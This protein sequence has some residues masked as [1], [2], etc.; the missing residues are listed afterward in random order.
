M[1]VLPSPANANGSE[2]GITLDLPHFSDIGL[3]GSSLISG[4]FRRAVF[5][6]LESLGGG[7]LE[8][9]DADGV[10]HFGDKDTDLSVVIRVHDSRFYRAVALGGSMGAGESYID[11]AWSCSD[12]TKLIQLFSRNL[13]SSNRLGG[14]ID[15]LISFARRLGHRLNRNTR[16]GSRKNISAHY[17]LSNQF[18]ELFLD[19][20]MTYSSG[21]FTSDDDTMQ[22]ASIEKYDRLCRKLSLCEDDHLLEIGTGWGGFSIH[23]AKHYGCRITTTTISKEQHA[24]AKKRIEVEGLQDQIELLCEDYRDLTGQYDK[25]VSIEMIEAVGHEF[26][27][28]YFQ[29]CSNLLKPNG[30]FAF[31]AITIPDQRYDSYRR[32]VDFIQRYVFPGGFLPSVGALASTVGRHTDMQWIHFEDFAEHYARTLECWRK[33]LF[34]KV[35]QARELGMSD[36]FLRLWEFYLCYCEGGFREKQIGVAQILLQKPSNRRPA[37][38]PGLG[39]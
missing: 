32:S 36:S 26:L 8:I 30:L 37:K 33:S 11:G 22:D 31:Q 29:Q 39:E 9:R 12:L 7:H 20:T 19:P 13:E 14:V 1:S 34:E 16:S 5:A 21:V 4:I 6:R 18:Y 27:P 24:Y 2:A 3:A 17:D 15:S 38:F 10:K 23:A 35:S 28:T 25:A